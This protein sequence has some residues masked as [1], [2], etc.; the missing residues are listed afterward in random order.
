MMAR[1]YYPA[2]VPAV[3]EKKLKLRCMASCS[4]QT[5]KITA[6]V[7]YPAKVPAVSEKAET[8]VHG[9]L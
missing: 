9:K 5:M 8:A 3:S 2:K 6:H 4:C 7:Y 1:V